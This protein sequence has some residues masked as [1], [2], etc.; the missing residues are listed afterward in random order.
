MMRTTVVLLAALTLAGCSRSASAPLRASLFPYWTLAQLP[1]GPP[2]GDPPSPTATAVLIAPGYLLTTIE[3]MGDV[4]TDFGRD[5]AVY[6]HDGAGWHAGRYVDR[7]MKLRIALIRADVAGTPVR[8]PREAVPA[9]SIVG[10]SPF[11]PDQPRASPF[12]GPRC[13]EAPR[14]FRDDYGERSRTPSVCVQMVVGN[15][16]GGVMLDEGGALASVQTM[17]FGV[18]Q[19]SGPDAAEIRDFLDL[20]FAT[21]G[22]AVRPKPEY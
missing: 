19:S 13:P 7:D 4:A 1:G 9:A 10:A 16:P 21:W 5:P 20:Y 22:S 11:E 6:V 15:L 12:G 14:W 2:K 17:P 18:G 8:L 3:G